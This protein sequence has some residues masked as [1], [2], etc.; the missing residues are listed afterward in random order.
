MQLSVEQREQLGK[1]L[2]FTATRSSGPGGQ[3]VNKVSTKVELRFSIGQSVFFDELKK[4]KLRLKLAGK[5][6]KEDELIL[7]SDTERSQ[8]KNKEKVSE[9]FF[10]LVE[11]ALTPEKKRIKTKPSKAAKLKRIEAKKQLSEKKKMRKN[12]K[13]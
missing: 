8:L 10:R 4:Q 11:D 2:K 7:V 12:P 6:N 1:E 13:L 9:R 3:H 5:I